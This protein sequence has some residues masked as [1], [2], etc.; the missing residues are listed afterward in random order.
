MSREY[1]LDDE[2]EK[3]NVLEK[4][5]EKLEKKIGNLE[6]R[7]Q[8]VY[9]FIDEIMKRLSL[10]T[11]LQSTHRQKNAQIAEY[12]RTLYSAKRILELPDDQNID[13]IPF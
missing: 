9:G 8:T 2:K 5:I 7:I 1:L 12:V 11:V 4:R 13:D 10:M 6:N 3:V